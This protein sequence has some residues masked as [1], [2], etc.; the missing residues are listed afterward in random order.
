MESRAILVGVILLMAT[1]Q[2]F[3]LVRYEDGGT[4]NIISTINDD[5][6]VDFDVPGMGTTV[7]LNSGGEI[8][9]LKAYNNS[10]VN[11]FDGLIQHS[12]DALDSSR[13]NVSGGTI[14]TGVFATSNSQLNISGG[15]IKSGLNA[16]CSSKITISG[17]QIDDSL[18]AYADSQIFIT[19][20]YIGSHLSVHHRGEVTISGG[21]IQGFV[22]NN[23]SKQ[24]TISG[25]SI[26]G[27]IWAGD[28]NN[29]DGIIMFAGS[30]FAINGLSVGYG[31]YFHSDFASGI[32]TGTLFN[33]GTLNNDFYINDNASIVLTPEP[34]TLLLLGFGALIIR[35]RK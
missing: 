32:L 8:Y 34:A 9:H 20:G 21:T 35:K 3:G 17:R 11:V 7:N 33:G 26:G 14:M 23:G 5:V 28:G 22:Q 12:L 10:L 31:Q 13:V 19:G 16:Q 2:G 27:E 25:G 1:G 15:L 6:W 4:Y 29:D 24:I 18:V 30:D